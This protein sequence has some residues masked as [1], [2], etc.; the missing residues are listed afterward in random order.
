MY[1][2]VLIADDLEAGVSAML[3]A[4]G[5]GP[6][7]PNLA[8]YS[9]YEV[10]DA[11]REKSRDYERWCARASDSVPTWASC[12]PRDPTEVLRTKAGAAASPSGGPT[13]PTAS[14]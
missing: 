13:T 6:I 9:W 12:T 4:H 2:R 8:L 10:D 5:I 1:G 11:V 3:Q 14:F 7:S